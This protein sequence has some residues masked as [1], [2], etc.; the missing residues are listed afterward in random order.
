MLHCC[1]CSY[2]DRIMRRKEGKGV[3]QLGACK[4]NRVFTGY[5]P[6][7]YLIDSLLKYNQSVM[8]PIW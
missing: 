7:L 8:F 3:V 6:S 4:V 5:T 1:R 2:D